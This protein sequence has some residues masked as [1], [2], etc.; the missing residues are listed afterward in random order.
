MGF[1]MNNNLRQNLE[2]HFFLKEDQ[3]LIENFKLMKA[4]KETK[5]ALRQV[6]GITNDSVL[7]RL[8]ELQIRP[9]T[10]ASL[11]M[12]PI[13]EVAWVDG[14]LDENEKKSILGSAQKQ[15]MTKGSVD[16][17]LLELWM[18]HKPDPSLLEAWT[19]YIEGLCEQLTAEQCKDLCK[20][21]MDHAT[22]VAMASGGFFGLGNKIS[23]SEELM[24]K[25]LS[26]TFEKHL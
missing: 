10:L 4:M 11:S 5:E 1:D 12:I 22:N 8:L 13:I 3:R 24:L 7:Q 6:S 26:K 21:L 14:V 2:D 15:G 9:E 23:K 17:K 20:E 25:Q 16:F 19:H 18:E